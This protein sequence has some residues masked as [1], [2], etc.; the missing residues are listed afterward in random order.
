[1]TLKE[2]ETDIVIKYFANNELSPDTL[3]AEIDALEEDNREVICLIVDYLKR[4]RSDN[5]AADERIKYRDITN[6]LKDLAIKYKIPVISAQ[7]INR[8][9]NMVIDSAMEGGKQDLARF[10]GR[11]NIAESWD[12]LENADWAAIL[13]V[14]IDKQDNRRYLTIKE[15]KKRYKS[16]TDI[17]YFNH[18]FEDGSTIMLIEDVNK[19][20]SVSKISLTSD[21]TSAEMVGSKRARSN[22]KDKTDVIGLLDLKSDD[23]GEYVEFPDQEHTQ[24]PI[25]SRKEEY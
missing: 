21:F 11:G 5:F 7:Q 20:E 3:E 12:I 19:E 14:E 25:V 13:N 10:L 16:H 22:G 17:T 4:M 18:P 15:I 23:L 1:L 24:G 8:S 6:G 9:G 2:G